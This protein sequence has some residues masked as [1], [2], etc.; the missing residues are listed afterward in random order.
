MGPQSDADLLVDMGERRS[1]FKQ[2]ALRIEFEDL[3]GCRVHVMTTGGLTYA[4]GDARERIEREAV[5][6]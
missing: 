6:L 3:L 2:A 1:L 4:S 5:A